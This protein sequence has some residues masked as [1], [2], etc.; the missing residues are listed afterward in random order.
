MYLAGAP[1]NAGDFLLRRVTDRKLRDAL[2]VALEPSPNAGSE[3]A[4]HFDVVLG[5]SMLTKQRP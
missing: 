2:I 1:E 3:L 4:A 5:S